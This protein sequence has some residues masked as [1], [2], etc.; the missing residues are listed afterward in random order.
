[1]GGTTGRR[2]AAV[3]T[4]LACLAGTTAAYLCTAEA[5]IDPFL[6]KYPSEACEDFLINNQ[7]HHE[8]AVA[9]TKELCK[10]DPEGEKRCKRVPQDLK[11]WSPMGSKMKVPSGEEESFGGW[12]WGRRGVACMRSTGCLYYHLLSLAALQKGETGHCVCSVAWFCTDR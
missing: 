2:G 3:A 5:N 9:T 8:W 7:D 12:F 6:A 11:G 10:Q 1:M 4:I